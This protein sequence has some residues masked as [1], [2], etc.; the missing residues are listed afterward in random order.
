MGQTYG[1]SGSEADVQPIGPADSA[2]LLP[3]PVSA[4]MATT[5]PR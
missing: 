4:S 5:L 2:I 3:V 1:P